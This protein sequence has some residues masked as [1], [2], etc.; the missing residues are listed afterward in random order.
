M[1]CPECMV[2][3]HQ[4]RDEDGVPQGGGKAEDSNY[5]TWEIKECP[6]CERLVKESYKCE[7]IVRNE[8]II[9]D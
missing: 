9:I 3:M 8:E 4:K 1:I 7:L 5:E 2:Q 6:S